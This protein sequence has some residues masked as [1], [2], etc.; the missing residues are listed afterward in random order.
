MQSRTTAVIMRLFMVITAAFFAQPAWC[1]LQL[2]TIG[3]KSPIDNEQN[4]C[5][6]VFRE[7]DTDRD[8]ML[9]ENEYVI[10]AGRERKMVRR[11]FKVF[12]ANADGRMNLNEFLTVPVGQSENQRGVIDD[13]VIQLAAKRLGEL[14]KPW[15]KWDAD[16]DGML[17]KREFESARIGSLVPGL[18]S[19]GFS[20]WDQDV[21]GW[22]SREDV[23]RTLEVAYGVRTAGG[24]LLRNNAG[25]VVDYITFS[26]LKMS[27]DGMVSKA[28]Y[29]A[30][31][32]PIDN[33]EFWLNSIDRN[34]DSRFDFA[35]YS[36][37]NHRTDPV[38]TFLNLDKDLD[39]LLSLKELDPLPDHWREMATFSF[40]GFDE[41]QDGAISLR[42]YQ[43]MPQCNLLAPWTEAVDPD[44]DG[45]LLQLRFS[46]EIFLS[47]LAAEY[48]Q[49]LDINGD[50]ALSHDEF[51]FSFNFRPLKVIE[52][53]KSSRSLNRHEDHRNCVY[54]EKYEHPW[55]TNF[56]RFLFWNFG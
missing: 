56:P 3:L 11:E 35:E 52:G 42:E 22:I 12:D 10:G 33:K 23:A 7:R 49:R 32:G 21:D 38:A 18:Q 5:V 40:K 9:S 24:A 45:K 43:L 53:R 16:R 20:K 44:H 17:D 48:F 31:L 55:G 30:A 27:D 19:A 25:L 13:P 50:H 4:P 8:G 34:Q 46:S 39:G 14:M 29:F 36:T 54:F 41:N 15:E 28:D 1:Q 2:P 51:K 47:A 37:G 26:R 6:L